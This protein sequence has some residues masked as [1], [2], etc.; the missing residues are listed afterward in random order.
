MVT[1]K[2]DIL[3]NVQFWLAYFVYEWLANAAVECEYDRYLVNALVIVPFTWMA[4]MFTVHVLFKRYY[5]G[6]RKKFFWAGLVISMVIFVLLRRGF[7]YYYTYPLYYPQG[8]TTMSYLFLPKLIIEGVSTYL[9]VGLYSMFYFIRAWY[10]QQ[11]LAQALLQAK[12]EAELAVLKAQV[13][14]HFMFNTLN[15]I[16][17]LS[18][19]RSDKAPDLIHRLS[20]FLSYNLYDGKAATI[21]LAK[22]LEHVNNYIE[23]EK[24][25]YGSR[26]DVS[27]N[28]FDPIDDFNISP[29]LLLPLV[30]NC[31]KHGV[32][33]ATGNCW[34]QID[35]SL[36]K[37]WLTVKFENS[38]S[39]THSHQNGYRNGIGLENVKRRLEII[40]PEAHEFRCIREQQSYL[41]VL[42]IKNLAHADQVYGHRR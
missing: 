19:Q 20:S 14:P 2:N 40:Y 5:L 23:L 28:V 12:V 1:R 42:K 17:S 3:F 39:L 27:V 30:E 11:R 34:I 7:N 35:I 36:Q 29:L 38:I 22:E 16:Y 26:L 25:R 6:N 33:S 15:N 13:H 8:N 18:L 4:A 32:T 31:F 41:S 21:P 10:E 37:D 9:I 24:I